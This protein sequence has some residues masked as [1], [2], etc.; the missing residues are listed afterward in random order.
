MAGDFGDP[1]S[2]TTRIQDN[3]DAAGLYIRQ[4][5]GQIESNREIV[6]HSSRH[7]GFT[8]LLGSHSDGFTET[9]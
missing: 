5:E 1:A 6:K 7:N 3:D 2:K 9:P 8:R 4:L